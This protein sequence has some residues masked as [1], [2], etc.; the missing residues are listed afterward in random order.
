MQKAKPSP[1][2]PKAPKQLP[3]DLKDSFIGEWSGAGEFSNG[4][5]I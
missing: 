1:S 5:K 4:K 2:A 3:A